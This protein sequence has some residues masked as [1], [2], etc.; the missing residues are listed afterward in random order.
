MAGTDDRVDPDTWRPLI[1]SFQKVYGLG[2][3]AHPSTLARIPQ[4]LYR[5]ADLERARPVQQGQP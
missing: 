5:S 1:M 3:Q 4:R 2:P